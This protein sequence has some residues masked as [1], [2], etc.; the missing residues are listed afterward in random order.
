MARLFTI[1]AYVEEGQYTITGTKS[2]ERGIHCGGVR[3][4]S[5]TDGVAAGKR[6][7]LGLS[8]ARPGRPCRESLTALLV[9]RELGLLESAIGQPLIVAAGVRIRPS[10]NEANRRQALEA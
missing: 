8:R 1:V 10:K 3:K 7:R 5:R 2:R 9:T 4:Y 6:P